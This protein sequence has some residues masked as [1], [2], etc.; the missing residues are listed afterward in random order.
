MILNLAIAQ[1]PI[2][3]H[4]NWD[5]WVLHTEKWVAEAVQQKAQLLLFPEYGSME[6]VSIF[7][8]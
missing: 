4:K 5:K 8:I 7:Q 3:E 1:Y 2:T 6:L